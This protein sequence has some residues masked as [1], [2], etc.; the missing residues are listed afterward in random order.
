M[1]V[2]WNVHIYV[3]SCIN[4]AV[5]YTLCK[6]TH[7]VHFLKSNEGSATNDQDLLD[8][9]VELDNV[10]ADGSIVGVLTTDESESVVEAQ[11]IFSNGDTSDSYLNYFSHILQ[12]QKVKG[13]V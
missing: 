9:L 13:N 5:Y 10:S 4:Y 2:K 6:H 8:I 11:P 12:S 1:I 3:C 7:L